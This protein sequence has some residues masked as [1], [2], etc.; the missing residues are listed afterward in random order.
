MNLKK[1]MRKKLD[2]WSEAHSHGSPSTRAIHY[3]LEELSVR[4]SYDMLHLA[5]WVSSPADKQFRLNSL[6]GTAGRP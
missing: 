3:V 6:M 2:S 1:S 4:Q 5:Q